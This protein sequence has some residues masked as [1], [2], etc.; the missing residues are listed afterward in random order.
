MSLPNDGL[1]RVNPATLPNA[2]L[3]AVSGDTVV[4]MDGI[5]SYTNLTLKSG[6]TYRADDGARPIIVSPDGYPPRVTINAGAHV[7]GLWFGGTKQ[8][9]QNPIT[10]TGNDTLLDGC[11][12]FSYLMGVLEGDTVSGNIYRNNR[13]VG[14]GE[15]NQSHA[16]YN[17]GDDATIEDNIFINNV[18]YSIHQWGYPE[19]AT[20]RRNFIGAA[21]T[22]IHFD[23]YET[24]CENNILWSSS[25]SVLKALRDATFTM[26]NNLI[27]GNTDDMI[28]DPSAVGVF[29]N[30][31]K[32]GTDI[33]EAEAQA[34]LGTTVANI[35]NT[36]T[37]IGAAFGES[38]QAIHDNANLETW[39]ATLKQLQW[40]A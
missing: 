4:F 40:S 34:I 29:E 31:P 32:I 14:C 15:E 35:N 9:A 18:A 39:F 26:Q 38:V 8:V 19:R 3:W 37:S 21:R 10:I 2:L 30:N 36:V 11:T 20:I 6:V 1:T 23:G 5:Y 33:T 25:A 27:G 17:A 12:I 13:F 24:L 7:S 28:L 16:L 22:C